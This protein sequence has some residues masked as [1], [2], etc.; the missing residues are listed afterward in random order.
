MGSGQVSQRNRNRRLH[1][2]ERGPPLWQRSLPG[3]HPIPYPDCYGHFEKCRE[4]DSCLVGRNLPLSCES[5]T[6]T[7]I[8]VV[9]ARNHA[10]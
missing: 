8:K 3:K 6:K 4:C 2:R 7:I 1:E 10:D 5:F 9:E